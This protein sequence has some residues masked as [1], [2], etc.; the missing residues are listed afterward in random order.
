MNAKTRFWWQWLVVVTVLITLFGLSM[1][2]MPSIIRQLFSV[3]I[4]SS[5]EAIDS[6]GDP[7]VA[8]LT[9]TQGVLGAVM[10]GWGIALLFVLFGSFRRGL[11][12]G[13]L[14]VAVS[15]AAWF[16]SD[17]AFSLWTGFWQ[18]AALNTIFLLA[19]AVPLLTTYPS[20]AM[21]KERWS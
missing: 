5:P 4:L 13:W 3:V 8:Y 18:N 16:I 15:V 11:K 6:F 20:F 1:V 21:N 7:A 12:E 19:F 2:L 17:T 14:T 10:F 9:L